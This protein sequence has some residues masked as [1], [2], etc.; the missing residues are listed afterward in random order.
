M[1][2]TST[3]TAWTNNMDK[4][5]LALAWLLA[6][7]CAQLPSPPSPPPLA[8][9]NELRSVPKQ[10]R[11]LADGHFHLRNYIQRGITLQQAH[12]LLLEQG[13][14]RAAVFG[15]PLQQRWDM[16]TGVSPRYYLHDD[17]NLY[18]YSAVDAMVAVEYQAL[19]E[20]QQAV[21]DPMIVGFNPTDGWAVDHIKHMLLTFPGTFTGI[22]EFSIKKEVVSGKIAGEPANLED[23]ALDQVLNFAAKV[24]LVVIFHCDV[25]AMISHNRERPTYLKALTALFDRHQNATII[26]AHTGL[27]RYVQARAEHT[28]W[29]GRLLQR[30][31]SLFVDISWDV[32]A[33]QFF[34][35]RRLRPEWR[36]FLVKHA[37]Q[38]IFGTD[39]V[40]PSPAKYAK[41]LQLYQQLWQQLPQDTVSAIA[42][43]NYKKLFDQARR[44]VRLWEKIAQGK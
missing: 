31:P 39:V 14:K 11:P 32:V 7:S 34:S 42:Y 37:K 22:G 21:F 23:P 28:Q 26:W 44:K 3:L 35:Q 1:T 30:Y 8:P 40:A 6:L 2:L 25:D 17:Q 43:G 18:Y 4:G 24:G 41:A 9:G 10:S 12:A 19:S 33:E 16:T 29:V 27:G 5:A 20:S 15:I 38:I 13:V 36:K